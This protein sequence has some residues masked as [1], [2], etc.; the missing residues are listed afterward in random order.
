[1][2]NQHVLQIPRETFFLMA[3]NQQQQQKQNQQQIQDFFSPF[4]Q[5]F[6]PHE[7]PII[8]FNQQDFSKLES[9]MI[10]LLSPPPSFQMMPYGYIPPID[11]TTSAN[12]NGISSCTT[13]FTNRESSTGNSL[14]YSNADSSSVN[15][16]NY[17]N[18][19]EIPIT[20]SQLLK[21]EEKPFKSHREAEQKRRDLLKYQ[22]IETKSILPRLKQNASKVEIL[23]K[24]RKYIKELQQE[25]KDE[26]NYTE[27]L[28]K[29]VQ[30]LNSQVENPVLLPEK[31]V[32]RLVFDDSD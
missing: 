23:K 15:G 8:S 21:M 32:T 19:R 2:C 18:N 12:S 16:S 5:P 24:C 1:M 28:K 26:R 29:Q 6:T 9:P 27:L 11:I 20:P 22:F 10:D 3:D 13:S 17:Y 30:T 31:H 4:I 14:N 25:L 7:S